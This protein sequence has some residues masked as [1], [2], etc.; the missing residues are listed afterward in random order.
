MNLI[1]KIIPLSIAFEMTITTLETIRSP[2]TQ[3]K[4]AYTFYGY[5]IWTN[6][7]MVKKSNLR[8]FGLRPE[9]EQ[10]IQ[11]EIKGRH[12]TLIFVLYCTFLM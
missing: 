2:C 11:G 5:Y 9:L 3:V 12:T 7:N 8:R 10:K 1:K 4:I 6:S